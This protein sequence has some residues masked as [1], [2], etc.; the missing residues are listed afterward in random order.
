MV[1]VA[2]RYGSIDYWCK[3]K[4]DR[5]WRSDDEYFFPFVVANIVDLNAIASSPS[6]VR[7]RFEE[8]LGCCSGNGVLR[9]EISTDKFGYVGGEVML[10]CVDIDNA[11][12]EIIC[13]IC[14]RVAE[15]WTY[16][17]HIQSR[18]KELQ[19]RQDSRCFTRELLSFTEP[20]M[21]GPQDRD[22]YERRIQLPALQPSY[23]CAITVHSFYVQVLISTD[24]VCCSSSVCGRVPF[25]VGIMPLRSAQALS[26]SD[27]STVITNEVRNTAISNVVQDAVID[28]VCC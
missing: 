26:P 12:S 7:R 4:V 16:K 22:R 6:P 3:A 1:L 10:L 20:V 27:K 2:G 28:D 21:I 14:V 8:E 23:G 25:Y 11:S 18:M 9:A 13:T 19:G 15:E 17:A 5:P 24:G